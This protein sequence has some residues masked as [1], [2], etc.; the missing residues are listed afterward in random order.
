MKKLLLAV[1]SVT[2]STSVGSAP[3][4]ALSAEDNY[5]IANCP[6]GCSTKEILQLRADYQLAQKEAAA[7][8][9]AEEKLAR[10]QAAAEAEQA[11]MEEERRLDLEE[12]ATLARQVQHAECVMAA[13]KE[14]IDNVPLYTVQCMT[15]AGWMLKGTPEQGAVSFERYCPRSARRAGQC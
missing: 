8:A 5:V 15:I 2:L 4:F 3:A 11:R 13:L 6:S 7:L 14:G 1:L 10:E 12:Q 9:R